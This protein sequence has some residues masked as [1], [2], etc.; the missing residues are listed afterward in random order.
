MPTTIHPFPELRALAE[1]YAQERADERARYGYTHDTGGASWAAMGHVSRY[2][3]VSV[4]LNLLCDLTR[5]AS[6]DAVCRLVADTLMGGWTLA[7]VHHAIEGHGLDWRALCAR[8][9]VPERCVCGPDEPTTAAESLALIVR[10]LW[11]PE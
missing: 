3:A 1:Q 6:R 5:N 10:H 7:R 2:I 9:L 8:G 4:E 11:P